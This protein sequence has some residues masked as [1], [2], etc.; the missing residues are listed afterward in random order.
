MGLGDAVDERL[1]GGRIAHVARAHLAGAA[2]GL[3]RRVRGGEPVGAAGD[4]DDVAPV[5]GEA[6]RDGAADA[7]ACSGDDGDAL[8]YD[9]NLRAALGGGGMVQ[10]G[11]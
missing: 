8:L 10:E 3:D 2:G 1:H 6:F 4:E 7:A 9:S 5:L 11:R